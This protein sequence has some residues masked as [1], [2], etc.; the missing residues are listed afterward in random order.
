MHGARRVKLV[1]TESGIEHD[2]YL[3]QLSRGGTPNIALRDF[4]F[5]I[6]SII[7]FISSTIKTITKNV[8]V[9]SV[10]ERVLNPGYS[11][12]FTYDLHKQWN[13]KLATRTVVNIF[14]NNEQKHTNDSVRKEQIVDFK[15]TKKEVVI[16]SVLNFFLP[17]FL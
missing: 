17:K 11:A 7:D 8:Y 12:I 4:I 10:S 6:F 15:E 3:Q 1:A 13:E 5:Q 16:I 2:D 9:W 14:F